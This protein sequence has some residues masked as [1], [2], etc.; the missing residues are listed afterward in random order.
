MLFCPLLGS[1]M[2]DIDAVV[3]M[4][5]SFYVLGSEKSDGCLSASIIV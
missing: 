1:F 5:S 2:F 3:V 4:C